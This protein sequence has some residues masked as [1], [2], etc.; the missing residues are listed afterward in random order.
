MIWQGEH[1]PN[2]EAAKQE[3]DAFKQKVSNVV[4][5]LVREYPLHFVVHNLSQFIIPKPDPLVEVLDKM[6]RRRF[7]DPLPDV[8]ADEA[9]WLRAKLDA[10]GFE[11][12][13]K[14]Q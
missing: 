4:E 14:S 8:L 2:C 10:L 3:F 1:C 11:I 12:R 7:L 5:L 13:E 9:H 6:L